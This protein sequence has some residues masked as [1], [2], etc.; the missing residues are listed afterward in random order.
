MILITSILSVS[1]DTIVFMN[2]PDIKF[3][4]T[5]YDITM[6]YSSKYLLNLRH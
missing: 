6:I 1:L 5:S 4:S 2:S 3:Y